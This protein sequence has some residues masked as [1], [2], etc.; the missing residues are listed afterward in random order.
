MNP[1]KETFLKVRI[2]TEQNDAL[3]KIAE[4]LQKELPQANVT[5]SSVVRHALDKYIEKTTTE[6]KS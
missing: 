2:T 4:E 3:K 1:N 6:A 5:I